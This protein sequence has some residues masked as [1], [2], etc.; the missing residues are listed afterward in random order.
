MDIPASPQST[1]DSMLPTARSED[2]AVVNNVH[3][4]L[5]QLKSNAATSL[6]TTDITTFTTARLQQV[7][8]SPTSSICAAER[9]LRKRSPLTALDERIQDGLAVKN[10]HTGI[11]IKKGKPEEYFLVQFL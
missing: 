11:L 4:Q 8:G 1:D 2:I 9:K 3:Q 10:I 5:M 7:D 6:I